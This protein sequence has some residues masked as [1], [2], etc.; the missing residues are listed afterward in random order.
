M[1]QFLISN[2]SITLSFSL[3][4]ATFMSGQL[5][6]IFVHIFFL[7]NIF[8]FF[9]VALMAV[10]PG[11]KI[12]IHN[13]ISSM[14]AHRHGRDSSDKKLMRQTNKFKLNCRKLPARVGRY[15]NPRK[16][17]CRKLPY[18]LLACDVKSL[19]ANQ[20]RVVSIVKYFEHARF[21]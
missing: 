2:L 13:C 10:T 3:F 8:L 20:N 18:R 19:S 12:N 11:W 7:S 6:Y 9:C 15:G 14:A 21:L 17:T 4:F 16:K 5:L 1:Q